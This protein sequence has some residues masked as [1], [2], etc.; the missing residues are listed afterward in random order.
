MK[1]YIAEA[2]A[3]AIARLDAAARNLAVNADA[4]DDDAGADWNAEYRNAR[5]ARNA[6]RFANAR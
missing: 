4:E 1:S 6:A 5:R 2:A 3:P